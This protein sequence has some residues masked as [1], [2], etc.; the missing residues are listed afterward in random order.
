MNR[1]A[2]CFPSNKI[3]THCWHIWGSCGFAPQLCS[4]FASANEVELGT[5][6]P[7]SHLS[8]A[9]VSDISSALLATLRQFQHNSKNLVPRP[10]KTGVLNVTD[11]CHTR[12]VAPQLLDYHPFARTPKLYISFWQ[13]NLKTKQLHIS[14]F[15]CV[16]R[17]WMPRKASQLSL[18]QW[19]KY[20]ASSNRLRQRSS[21]VRS[22][23][24]SSRTWPSSGCC[25]THRSTAE[26]KVAPLWEISSVIECSKPISTAKKLR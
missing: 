11:L 26:E 18:L 19:Y 2:P 25:F 14:W 15:S 13:C 20:Q 10:Y 5:R 4:A 23:P 6:K 8:P 21:M 1:R 24:C 22:F 3:H 16:K 9:T 17:H 12:I 7:Q